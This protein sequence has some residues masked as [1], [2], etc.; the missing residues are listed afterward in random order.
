[1]QEIVKLKKYLHTHK[2]DEEEATTGRR[3]MYVLASGEEVLWVPGVGISEKL[4][5]IDR[6]THAIKLLDIAIGESTFC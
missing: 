3:R 2:P 1:M 4:R 6:P 5:V